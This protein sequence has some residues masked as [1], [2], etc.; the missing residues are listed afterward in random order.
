MAQANA[1]PNAHLLWTPPQLKARLG[2]KNLALLDVRSTHQVMTGIIPGAAHL[3]LYGIGL[4]TTREP[5]FDEF[6]NMMRSQFGLRG[7]GHD[8]TVVVYEERSGVRAGRAFWLL[9]YMGHTDVHV[10]DGGIVAWEAAGYEL[11]REMAAPRPAS[12]PLKAR[13]ETY[14]GADDLA[15][16]LRSKSVL[17]LDTRTDDEYYGRNTRGG[18]RGGTVPG[19]V[20]LEWERYLD[21][22]GRFLPAA[23]LL[24]L[25][26][27][28]GVTREKPIVPF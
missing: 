12:L 11:T 13:P 16:R 27:S 10:L 25:F 19:A 9:E 4:T 1:F 17:P 28:H 20:H 7:I 6:V 3:D 22:H 26:E 24:H 15:A 23:K 8:K 18:P 5:L 21:E 14:I 2:E